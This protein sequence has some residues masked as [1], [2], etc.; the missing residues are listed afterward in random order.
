MGDTNDNDDAR[1]R[2]Q[3]SLLHGASQPPPRQPQPGELLMTFEHRQDVYRVE[4][5]DFQ[6]HGVEGQIFQNGV[7]LEGTRF[8]VRALVS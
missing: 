5:R 4:L 1:T 7:L 8:T 6:P 2:H 3:R